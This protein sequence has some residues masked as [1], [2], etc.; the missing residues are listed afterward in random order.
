MHSPRL[1]KLLKTVRLPLETV[2][3]YAITSASVL[4]VAGIAKSMAS[5]SPT[6]LA[7]CLTAVN[8]AT[9]TAWRTVKFRV[10]E[11]VTLRCNA[12]TS[13]SVIRVVGIA[14]KTARLS[15]TAWAAC[16]TAVKPAMI[17]AWPTV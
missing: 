6:A 2:R 17:T 5:L 13:A 4:H 7:A 10:V 16:L 14:K 3:W 1:I 11:S 8:P 12:I 9:I 15:P